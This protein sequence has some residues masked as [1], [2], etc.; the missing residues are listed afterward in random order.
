[1]IS[2]ISAVIA[3][4]L[5]AVVAVKDRKSAANRSFIGML[6]L[7]AGVEVVRATAGE[8][9]SIYP[10]ALV[11]GSCLVFS[12]C[13]A[14]SDYRK[15]LAQWKY[16]IAA[17]Y[18]IP[19]AALF[20]NFPEILEHFVL[21]G[22]AGKAFFAIILLAAVAILWN[23]ERTVRASIGY[24]RWQIK[25]VVLGMGTLCAV[26]LYL[27]SQALIYSALD[28]YLS[29]LHPI[30]LI[31]ACGFFGW[32][33]V[34]SSFL[35]VDVYL[36][37]T[38][39]QYSLTGLLASLYLL[40]LGLLAFRVRLLEA[41]SSLPLHALMV[42]VALSG[43]AVLLLSDRVQAG[44]KR[45][46]T[47]HFKR[48]MYDYRKA[49]MELSENTN[50][51]INVDTICGTVAKIV[52]R[53]FGILSV[54]IWLC[55]AAKERLA[56]AG[57][58]VFTASQIPDLERSGKPVSQM[59]FALEGSALP[60]DLKEKTMDWADD[61]MRSEPKYFAEFKMRY[62]LPLRV[63]GQ[64]IG[65]M[66]LNEDRVGKA[67]LSMED[68]DLLNAYTAHLAARVLQLRLSENVRKTQEIEAFQNVSAFFV[69]DLKNL[70][71][72]LSLTMQNLPVYFDNPEFRA[73]ALKL[74]GQSASKID[75]T[76]G[77]LSSL[78]KIEIRP[79][80][81]D[82]NELLA[83]CVSDF[84]CSTNTKVEWDI[85]PVPEVSI[86]QEQIQKVITNLLLNAH[87]AVKGKG[88]IKVAASLSDQHVQVIV[89]DNGCGMS[90]AFIDK[91]LFRPFTSTKKRGMGIGLFH[92]KMIAEAHKG[93]IEVDS[94]EGKGTTF[95]V[96]L[97]I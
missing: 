7:L 90:R 71:S 79:L 73:D 64:L 95:R 4:I 46:V 25:F 94:E 39:I 31:I 54:N 92:S 24:I 74:I 91:M 32:G 18:M 67:P 96:I 48:P 93:K 29:I 22:I 87:D 37:R 66:T 14:R 57:S 43:L 78:K 41:P 62:L 28:I 55:D 61:I 72:R 60:V 34:R 70:A 75:D 56:L 86:D 88:N 11:P 53:T 69:H 89:S 40:I 38:T 59:L 36:S 10:F 21:L 3:L 80:P 8:R 81:A 12:L 6:L 1:M 17:C 15:Y 51:I 20:L 35:N 13:F 42:L 77:R 84:E 47:R 33:L 44:L 9:E 52:S 82:L 2:V 65:V 97:P 49:W 45:M 19:I 68:N 58:T 23:L 85:K 27:S 83:S 30:A 16:L 50:S 5:A 26:W 76:I 63:G